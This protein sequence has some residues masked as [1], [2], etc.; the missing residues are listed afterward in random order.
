MLLLKKKTSTLRLF[1]EHEILSIKR[2]FGTTN[3]TK[4]IKTFPLKK[5]L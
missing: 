4:N 3:E 5:E 1:L 2:E